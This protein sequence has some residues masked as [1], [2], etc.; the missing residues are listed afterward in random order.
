MSRFRHWKE[1]WSPDAD[2]YYMR[3]LRI[4]DGYCKVGQK[5]SKVTRERLGN[6][7]LKRWFL[8]GTLSMSPDGGRVVEDYPQVKKS[9]PWTIIVTHRGA[10]PVKLR[11]E[12]AVKDFLKMNINPKDFSA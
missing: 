7:R 12:K 9:G 1:R 8:N 5:V 10:D 4:E 3:R 11:G 6:Y 2:L